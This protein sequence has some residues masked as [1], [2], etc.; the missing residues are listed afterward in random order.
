M[1]AQLRGFNPIVGISG[2]I[3]Q[4]RFKVAWDSLDEVAAWLGFKDRID[5]CK[6]LPR[7]RE[8]IFKRATY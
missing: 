8:N 1:V 7:E 3:G 2:W 6:K 5:Y 4:P